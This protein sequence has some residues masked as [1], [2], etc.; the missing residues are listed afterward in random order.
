[1]K[2][3][4]AIVSAQTLANLIPILMER[5]DKVYLVCSDAMKDRGLDSRI[6]KL[7]EGESIAVEVKG[8]APDAG[9][10]SIQNYARSLAC[11]IR[12]NH[13]DAELVFNA[14]GGT[15]LM[16]L[17]FVEVF[18]NIA[19]SI[20]YTDTSRR[21]IE[22]FPNGSSAA[23]PPTEMRNVFDVPRYLAAQGFRYQ[24]ARSDGADWRLQVSSRGAA[25]TYLAQHVQSK[26]IQNLIGC[27]N[28]LAHAALDERGE[29]LRD[30]IQSFSRVPQGAWARALAEMHRAGLINWRKGSV[31]LKFM[32]VASAMFIGGGWL[33]EFAWRVISDHAVHDVRCGVEVI[34]DEL[35][36]VRNEFDLL[37]CHGN[38]LLVI[39]CKTLRHHDQTDSDIAYKIDSIGQQ[40]R[41]L[42][43][44]TWLLSARAPT[45]T[46]IERARQ[47]RIRIIGPA[48]LPRL[49]SA[50][51]NWIQGH[52]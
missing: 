11:E 34:G 23:S 7:L 52:G 44:E 29:S 17:G 9:L 25:C 22:I 39:E 2:I 37:A 51:K 16:S 4:I 19:R 28:S 47:A 13:P 46:L 48:E 45:D 10:E 14:T 32:N 43:G 26:N 24:N 33:E 8:A 35:P 12:H 42:F 36:H 15:K 38:E 21:R 31:Q 1:M 50:I 41:G 49:Q 30:P 6:R 40:V 5:P 20:I 3:H 27:L 18:R